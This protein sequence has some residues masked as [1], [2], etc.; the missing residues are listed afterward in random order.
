VTTLSADPGAGLSQRAVYD[1][2][3]EADGYDLR[4]GVRVLTA[5][6][7]ALGAAL[8]RI[9]RQR[10]TCDRIG[11]FDFGYG[12][13]RVT[14]EFLLRFLELQP[15]AANTLHVVAYDVSSEGLRK[16]ADR[17][18]DDHYFEGLDD[19]CWDS[20][21]GS[22]YVVGTLTRKQSAGT[23]SITFIHGSETDSLDA[24]VKLA[25]VYNDGNLFDICTSW[26]SGIGHVPG[27]TRRSE[28]FDAFDRL[29]AA[30][31][32][33]VIA[34]SG[35]GDLVEHD[36]TDIRSALIEGAG[37]LIY[38]TELGQLNYWHVFDTDLA[39]HV[40]K[41]KRDG[42]FCWIE[43]I[44]YPGD[45]FVDRNAERPNYED[46]RA[47][48]EHMKDQEW[49]PQHYALCHTVAAIRSAVAPEQ[50]DEDEMA[51]RFLEKLTRG[52]P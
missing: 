46:V 2:R 21:S 14:N 31:G 26:Y 13:G 47:L 8:A 33:M 51:R 19:L 43:A 48:N 34:V 16:A 27:E 36:R 1:A 52:M 35:T 7:E 42:Q 30:Q 9:V 6:M 22:T 29:T 18:A 37:D 25:V 41:I 45:E 3:Y 32:E 10:G 40:R 38:R 20:A 12:T 49:L 23:L 15:T 17:L 28:Y 39:A 11:I 5:E 44:R 24:M 50:R 4:A